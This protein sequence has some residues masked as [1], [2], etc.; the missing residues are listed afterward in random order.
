MDN[1]APVTTIGVGTPKYETTGALYVGAGTTFGLA[2]T[3]NF[4]GVARTEYRVDEGVWNVYAEAFTLAPYAEGE[5]GI[6]YRSTDNAGNAESARELKVVLDKTSPR[7]S[8]L[9]RIPCWTAW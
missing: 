6:H 4:S 9:H 2:A 5:H 1:R 3:D 7:P 8:S